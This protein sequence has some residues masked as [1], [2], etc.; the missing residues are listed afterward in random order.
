[1]A[2]DGKGRN[3]A[4]TEALIQAMENP[5]LKVEEVFKRVRRQVLEKTN[6]LQVPWE[7]SSLV[8]DFRFTRSAM[9]GE[10]HQ[11]PPRETTHRGMGRFVTSY[12]HP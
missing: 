8:G 10:S 7:S 6:S 4:Y 2:S 3:G 12:L 9:A 1:M 11:L 5:G